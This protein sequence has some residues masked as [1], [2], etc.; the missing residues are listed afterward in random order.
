[1]EPAPR[2]VCAGLT[3]WDVVHLVSRLPGSDEKVAALDFFTAAGGPATN[4]AVA[5]AHL[6]SRPTLATT[7]PDHPVS[8]LIADDLAKCGVALEVAGTYDG[9]PIS[10]S[11]MI[12]AGTGDRAIVSPTS[13]AT[14]LDVTPT[15]LPDTH[16]VL[17]VLVD[18]YFRS[19]S[20]PIARAARERG[21]PVILDAGSSRPYT[22]ELL[23]NVD[24]AVPSA[25]FRPLGTDGSPEAVFAY[26]RAR[27]VM[28]SAI[29]RGADSVLYMCPGGS[30]EVS[31]PP[32]E[33]VVDTLGAGDFFHGALAHRIATLGLDGDRFPEDLAFAAR[34]VA[35]SITSFGTRSWLTHY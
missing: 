15:T 14:A 12:T 17:C 27:G 26:L 22:D 3:T 23:A 31:V 4:A 13:A 21:V 9:P 20:L 5:V 29:T 33:G 8:A 1:M 32:V 34:V 35:D 11:I 6:G 18:G 2:V 19:I 28:W 25:A 30:G 10:A 16:N 7:L 24:V